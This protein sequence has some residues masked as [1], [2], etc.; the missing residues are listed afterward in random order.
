M[1]RGYRGFA[2]E[3]ART[4]TLRA[5]RLQL[6][7]GAVH[8]LRRLL[9]REQADPVALFFDNYGAD[10][11]RPPDRDALALQLDAE[12]CLVCGLCSAECARVGGEPAVDPR[13][14]VVAASR[15]AIDWVR[16]GV[17]PITGQ[18]DAASP[19]AG[20]RACEF[21]CP[22]QIPIARIQASLA[23]PSTVLASGG[24]IF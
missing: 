8:V 18:P 13:D 10:G 17:G 20:C 11:F 16:L 23:T 14:A 5:L 19:C 12:A 6:G 21:A 22:V 2:R 1:T 15:L 3:L 24:R 4:G 9:W 7:T